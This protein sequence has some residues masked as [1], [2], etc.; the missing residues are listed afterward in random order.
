MC[1]KELMQS[2]AALELESQDNVGKLQLEIQIKEEIISSL[3]KEA[4]QSEK[5]IEAMNQQLSQL[6]SLV[7]EK[8][9]LIAQHKVEEKERDDRIQQ[10]W[11]INFSN[12]DYQVAVKNCT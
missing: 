7:E 2:V 11:E 5:R 4:G 6:Q 10:V 9:Q 8:E 1:Q 12:S 3:H